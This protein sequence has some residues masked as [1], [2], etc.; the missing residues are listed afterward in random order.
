MELSQGEGGEH[1][2]DAASYYSK[3]AFVRKLM[4]VVKILL[5][6]NAVESAQHVVVAAH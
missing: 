2:A 3:Y 6:F 1:D 5:M 4:L